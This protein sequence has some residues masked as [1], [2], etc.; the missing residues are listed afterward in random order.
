[1]GFALTN[2]AAMDVVILSNGP[3]ELVTWVRPVVVELRQQLPQARLSL[4]LAPCAHASGQERQIAQDYLR[5]D[6]I[7][8]ADYFFSF[9]LTGETEE[10]WD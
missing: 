7:Q 10:R 9:L 2:T 3:G 1:M 6:R 4:I 5:V 8:D